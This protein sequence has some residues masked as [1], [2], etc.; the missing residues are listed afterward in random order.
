MTFLIQSLMRRRKYKTLHNCLHVDEKGN[1]CGAPIP[2]KYF[3]RRNPENQLE[4]CNKHLKMRVYKG[5]KC[6]FNKKEESQ[7]VTVQN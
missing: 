4:L 5:H 1:V 3:T 2:A 6:G 7:L